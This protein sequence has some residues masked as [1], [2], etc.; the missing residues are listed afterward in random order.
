V[1]MLADNPRAPRW[2]ESIPETERYVEAWR[3]HH[4]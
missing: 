1:I 2:N 4:R 3:E